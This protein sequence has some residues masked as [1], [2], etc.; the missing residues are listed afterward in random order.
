M[1]MNAS[2]NRKFEH[3]NVFS[4]DYYKGQHHQQQYNEI[5]MNLTSDKHG[6]HQIRDK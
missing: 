6:K 4:I 1:I 5:K 3:L 2:T